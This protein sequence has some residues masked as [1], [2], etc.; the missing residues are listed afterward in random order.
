MLVYRI[1]SFT[2]YYAYEIDYVNDFLNVVFTLSII[3]YQSCL[4]RKVFLSNW[5]AVTGVG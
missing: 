2:W 4:A 5:S 1:A 3:L